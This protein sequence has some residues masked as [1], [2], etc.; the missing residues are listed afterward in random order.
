MRCVFVRWCVLPFVFNSLVNH[1]ACGVANKRKVH[2]LDLRSIVNKIS[3][4]NTLNRESEGAARL[5]AANIVV[6][7]VDHNGIHTLSISKLVA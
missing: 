1:R 2:E 4:V 7:Q 6:P 3:I 5:R